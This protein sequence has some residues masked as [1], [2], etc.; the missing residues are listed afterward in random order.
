MIIGASM[1]YHTTL[2]PEVRLPERR[3]TCGRAG[4][5]SMAGGADGAST[6]VATGAG[7]NGRGAATTA[8]GI[9]GGAVAIGSAAAGAG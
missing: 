6:A 3:D 1:K 5:C 7:G 4:A 2:H 9:A 8:A